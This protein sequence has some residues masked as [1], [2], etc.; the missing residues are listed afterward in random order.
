MNTQKPHGSQIQTSDSVC[1]EY[2]E[3]AAIVWL[4]S[5]DRTVNVMDASM[6]DGLESALHRI[7]ADARQL[8]WIAV[9]SRKPECFLAGAD[10]QRIAE[11]RDEHE[12]ATIIARGQRLMDRIAGS[13]IPTIALL[14]GTCLGGGLE[15][16]LACKHRIACSASATRLGLPEVRLGLIPGWGGTQR[17]P[18]LVG[19][20]RAL[21]LILTGRQISAQQAMRIGLVDRMVDASQWDAGRWQACDALVAH[22]PTRQR[23]WRSKLLDETAIGRWL[24]LAA[25]RR[26]I[27]DRRHH[28][29]ALESAIDAVAAAVATGG[30]AMEVERRKFVQLIF[31]TTAQNLL[32]I[33]LDRDRARKIETWVAGERDRQARPIRQVAVV[34]GGTMGSAIAV[35]AARRGLDVW[36]KEIDDHALEGARTRAAAL[37]NKLVKRGKIDAGEARRVEERLNWTIQWSDL[38]GCDLAVE[39]VLEIPDVKR[40]VFQM[41]DRSLRQDAILASNTSSLRIG[42]IAATTGRPKQILG[43]HFF[44]PV[45]RM[46][47]VEVI[48]C[49]E[50]DDATLLRALQFVRQMGKTPVV[51]AD[52]PGFIVNRILFPYLGEAVRMVGEGCSVQGIDREMRRFGMPMGPLELI[53]QVGVDIAAHVAR[54]LARIQPD[55]EPAA[56]VLDSLVQRQWLGKK[57]GCGFYRHDRSGRPRPNRRLPFPTASPQPIGGAFREDG[58]NRIQQRLVY[59]MLNEAVRCLDEGIAGA[60]WVIDLAMVLGTG[61]APMHG[62]PLRLVHAIGRSTVLHNMQVLEGLYGHRFAPADGLQHPSRPFPSES[63]PNAQPSGS[64]SMAVRSDQQN[65]EKSDEHQ[66]ATRS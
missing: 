18:I 1:L 63:V 4:D 13:R 50:T 27:A 14:R 52:R 51:A 38:A 16:A 15:L 35:E 47:L 54:S 64:A 12:V 30:R 19:S 56:A 55:A 41:A 65:K 23:E 10:V 17:L 6:L 32:R 31:T 44:N 8:R 37:L 24:V 57:T 3:G 39:A 36:V 59:P 2:R 45:D 66:H 46:E 48:R 60:P 40:E 28:Y 49:A 25:A 9:A 58:M 34:G 33:F 21:D 43:I 62:G 29:P 7:D 22:P 20:S 26:R 42:E 53:D 11:L 61:F 5:P